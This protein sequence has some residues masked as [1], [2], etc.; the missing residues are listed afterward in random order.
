M[1]RGENGGQCFRGGG[2]GGV[3][4]RER[5]IWLNASGRTRGLVVL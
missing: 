4:E 1:K 3:R 5:T 2:G